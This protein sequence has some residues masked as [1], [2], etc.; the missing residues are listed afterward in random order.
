MYDSYLGPGPKNTAL[1]DWHTLLTASN[2][3]VSLS[4]TW[5]SYCCI[6]PDPV[7]HLTRLHPMFLTVSP[8]H[9]PYE[10]PY[11]LFDVPIDVFSNELGGQTAS[12]APLS[13]VTITGFFEATKP[14][15][16]LEKF[17]VSTKLCFTRTTSEIVLCCGL[18]GL[19]PS[20]VKPPMDAPENP[21]C[22]Y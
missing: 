18:A 1:P 14:L 16:K 7:M 9:A 6:E 19:T 21:Y 22:T 12:Q 3:F 5:K 8:P 13:I 17:F 10:F 15:G 11:S 20:R 4:P 2:G